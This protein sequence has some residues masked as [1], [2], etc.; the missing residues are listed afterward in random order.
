M[1]D[2]SF[3]LQFLKTTFGAGYKLI[4]DKHTEIAFTD[5]NLHTLVHFV[6]SN[7]PH[8]KHV[9][10]DGSEGQVIFELPFESVSDFHALGV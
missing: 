7:V 9:E 1:T 5:E 8:A 4:F 2:K 6:Q 3:S 10:V